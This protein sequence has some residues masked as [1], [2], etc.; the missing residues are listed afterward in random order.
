M[1]RRVPVVGVLRSPSPEDVA[2]FMAAAVPR[3]TTPALRRTEATLLALEAAARIAGT[4][5]RHVLQL[6]AVQWELLQRGV[7]LRREEV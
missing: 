2:A 5:G 1:T 7:P 4:P 6:A 3:E